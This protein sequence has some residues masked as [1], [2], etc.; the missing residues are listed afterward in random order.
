MKFLLAAIWIIYLAGGHVMATEIEVRVKNIEVVRGGNLVV[1]LFREQGFPK[2]HESA[3]QS[4]KAGKLNTEMTFRFVVE[5][6]DLAIKIHHDE[7][8]NGRVTK[9]W[10]GIYPKEGLGFSNRQKVTLTGPP[11]YKRSKLNVS[12]AETPIEISMTYP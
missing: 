12:S 7:D 10:T 8:S 1:M 11:K 6:R 2:C 9:N 3:V 4:R 5:E